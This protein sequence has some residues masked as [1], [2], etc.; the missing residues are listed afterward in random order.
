MTVRTL[1]DRQRFRPD[2]VRLGYVSGVFGVRGEVRLFL[3]NPASRLL[4][5]LGR[6]VLVGPQGERTAV[7]LSVRHGAGKRVLGRLEGVSDPEAAR[8]LTGHELVVA[9]AALPNVAPG[10]FYHHQL[11]GLPVHEESGGLLGSLVAIHTTGE[12][13][14]W[15][16]RGR[17]ETHYIPAMQEEILRVMPG[18]RIVVCD[19]GAEE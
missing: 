15:E 5:S 12:V 14:V 1:P 7:A 11:L 3:Y 6:V 17:R 8:A 13:D 19:G 16:V 9:K 10:T 2:E 18:D 4:W